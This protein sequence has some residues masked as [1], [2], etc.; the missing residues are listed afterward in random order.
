MGVVVMSAAFIARFA[1]DCHACKERI[2]R[3]DLIAGDRRLGYV[4]ANCYKPAA[5]SRANEPDLAQRFDMDY[6]DQ[7]R[8]ACGPGL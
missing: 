7:C 4:H 6:E 8:D 1:G 5:S 3:G 2:R